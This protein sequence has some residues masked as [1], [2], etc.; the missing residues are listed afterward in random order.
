VPI[1]FVERELGASKMSRSI[2]IEALWR[3]TVWGFTSRWDRLRGK[4]A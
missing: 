2:M 1:T 4:S 3:V